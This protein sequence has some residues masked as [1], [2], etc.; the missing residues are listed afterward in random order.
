MP[1]QPYD[2]TLTTSSSHRSRGIASRRPQ[3]TNPSPAGTGNCGAHAVIPRDQHPG[4]TSFLADG[5]AAEAGSRGATTSAIE[6]A[7]WRALRLFIASPDSRPLLAGLRLQTPLHRR[8]MEV[9]LEVLR[10]LPQ[11]IGEQQDS[12]A[13][14]VRGL[15]GRLEPE[16]GDLLQ[17][18][19]R[20]GL[21]G[22]GDARRQ[23]GGGGDGSVGCFGA[24]EYEATKITGKARR[25]MR[26]S[27]GKM[28]TFKITSIR[29]MGSTHTHREQA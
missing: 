25:K 12:L 28:L 2:T 16:L 29:R 27:R 3:P 23:F 4:R 11:E 17:Q 14:A 18:L 22:S 26:S 6:R 19:C 8:A 21:E 13:R 9:L 7:E 10:R 1:F 20:D 24:G 15:C 5:E